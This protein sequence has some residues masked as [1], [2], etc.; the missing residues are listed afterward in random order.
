MKLMIT[1]LITASA[2]LASAQFSNDVLHLRDSEVQHNDATGSTLTAT[3]NFPSSVEFNETG[4]Y[5]ASGYANQHIW[6]LSANGTSDYAFG[7]TDSWSLSFDLTLSDSGT[8]AGALSLD[9]EAGFWVADPAGSGNAGQFIVKSDG[10]V[11][12]FGGSLTFHEFYSANTAGDYQLG[13]SIL[14]SLAYNGTTGMMTSSATYN[15]NE[16]TF[17]DATTFA[18]G[19]SVGGYAQYQIT[20]TLGQA[21]TGDAVFSNIQAAPEPASMA[22]LA[23][24]AVALIR[25]RRNSKRF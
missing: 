15:G 17:T 25:R 24:G 12:Q 21:N 2:A 22:A 11:A 18:A 5:A 9:K 16:Q 3:N 6:N 23:L 7:A 8:D 1:A 19:Y 20:N 4:L 14:M 13:T 10:E